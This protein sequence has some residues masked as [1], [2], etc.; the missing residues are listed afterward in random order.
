MKR[1]KFELLARELKYDVPS[2][3]TV[4]CFKSVLNNEKRDEDREKYF[5]LIVLKNVRFQIVNVGSSDDFAGFEL[6]SSNCAA[7]LQPP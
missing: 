1:G 2:E 7:A 3:G 4:E 6:L 5:S